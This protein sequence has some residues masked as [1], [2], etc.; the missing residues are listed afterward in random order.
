[1]KRHERPPEVCEHGNPFGTCEICREK[2]KP[3]KEIRS[4]KRES[5]EKAVGVVDVLEEKIDDKAVK[6]YQSRREKRDQ[7]Y[8]EKKDNPHD[9]AIE[10]GNISESEWEV[11]LP[12]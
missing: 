6:Y 4:R 12:E 11:S 1:M 5:P 9:S 3:R 7:L 8:W 10:E 2:E